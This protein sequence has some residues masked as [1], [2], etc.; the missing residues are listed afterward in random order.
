LVIKSIFVIYDN[1][2]KFIILLFLLTLSTNSFSKNSR[3]DKMFRDANVEFSQNFETPSDCKSDLV[4]T[5]I[6]KSVVIGKK[7]IRK[8]IKYLRKL[9][10]HI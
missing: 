3:F 10:R 9:K 1:M 5:I 2:I 7:D 4:N 8:N 6:V